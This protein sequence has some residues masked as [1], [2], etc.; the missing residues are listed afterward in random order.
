MYLINIFSILIFLVLCTGFDLKNRA[1]PNQFL[2]F[3]FLITILLNLG[4]LIV[5]GIISPLLIIF[6]VLIIVMAF[7]LTLILFS[8]NLMGGA[9]GKIL[10]LI[11][12]SLPIHLL[13]AFFKF[14]FLVLA[15]IIIIIHFSLF[16]MDFVIMN[17]DKIFK[18]LRFPS[19][20]FKRTI[21]KVNLKISKFNIMR[22]NWIF[23]FTIPILVSY[24]IL[25]L[26]L[27]IN[28]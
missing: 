6:R 12:C 17:I 26:I 20:Q 10:I 2:R 4:E 11:F 23:P 28:P 18:Y 13:L 7:F 14:Y 15:V 5:Y 25:T 27:F 9:D 1:I 8:L 22:D 19:L 24:V 3:Y 16:I 21:S